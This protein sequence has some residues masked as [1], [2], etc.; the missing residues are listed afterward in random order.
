MREIQNAS[1]VRA[2]ASRSALVSVRAAD[3]AAK[4]AFALRAD[5]Y[6]FSEQ[7]PA[8]GQELAFALALKF[9]LLLNSPPRK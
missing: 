7:F 9:P 3:P 1:M 8:S 6:L 5:A 4:Q 2:L